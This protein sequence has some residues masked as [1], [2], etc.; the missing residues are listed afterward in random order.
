MIEE[1]RDIAEY[2]GLYQVSNFGRV[3]RVKTS[4]EPIKQSM[5]RNG[6]MK[7]NL[8]KNNIVKTVMVHRL[9][10]IAFVDNPHN[11]AEVNHIDGDKKNNSIIN[12]EWTTR[13]ENLKHR[14]R[15]LGQTNRKTA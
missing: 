7:L 15:I 4:G 10:A 9:V 1:W 3:R 14:Y 2:E 8:C 5:I 13:S 12:L 11:K 6:Y